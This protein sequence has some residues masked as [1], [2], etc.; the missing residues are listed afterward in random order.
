MYILYNKTED[1]LGKIK[2]IEKLCH[3]SCK[4]ICITINREKNPENS[5]PVFP[6]AEAQFGEERNKEIKQDKIFF[7]RHKTSFSSSRVRD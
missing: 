7:D 5:S 2:K 3:D 1:E 4:K 6:K